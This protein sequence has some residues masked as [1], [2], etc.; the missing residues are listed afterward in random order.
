MPAD[1]GL[2]IILGDRSRPAAHR[3]RDVRDHTKAVLKFAGIGAGDVVADFLPFR[4][5]FTR[6]FTAM[7][8]PDGRVLAAVP[9]ELL[10]IE[11]IAEGLKDVEAFAKGQKNVKI[12]NGPIKTLAGL[13]DKLDAFWIGQNY[14][15]LHDK[16]MGPV[17]IAAFNVAVFQKLRA[18]G[19]YI[20]SDH[21]AGA[22]P[23]ADVTERLHR[24]DPAMVRREVKAAG[25]VY[26]GVSRAMR[27]LSDTHT[28]SVFARSIRYHTDRFV[29][30]FRK[31]A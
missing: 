25:F 18:G 7:V 21:S 31:P 14:H 29:M 27:N 26:V 1:K 30:K 9:R 4:G 8:G 22:R 17:D 15:D 24:I 28:A 5:Y 23:E 16:F 2:D 19:S 13:P 3:A 12:L 10:K 6:L 20:L 11:R